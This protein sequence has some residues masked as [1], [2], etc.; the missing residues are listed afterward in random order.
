MTTRY[1]FIHLVHLHVVQVGLAGLSNH[2]LYRYQDCLN[3]APEHW[4]THICSIYP[5]F[6]AMSCKMD[7]L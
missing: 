1:K 3:C 2:E 6:E 5:L 4:Y 7:D